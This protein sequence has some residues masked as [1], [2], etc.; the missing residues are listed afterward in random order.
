MFDYKSSRGY[1]SSS[2]PRLIPDSPALLC[3]LIMKL[4]V[5]ATLLIVV[6]CACA[7]KIVIIGAGAAGI[8]AA[9]KLFGL[10]YTDV[11]ILEAQPGLGGRIRTVSEGSKVIEFGAEWLM[12]EEGN[13]LFD[14]AQEKDIKL[15]PQIDDSD[16][17]VTIAGDRILEDDVDSL[18]NSY[19]EILAKVRTSESLVS[20]VFEAE[21]PKLAGNH[22]VHR[23]LFKYYFESITPS[24]NWSNEV[25][26]GFGSYVSIEGNTAL[27]VAA[28]ME[29]LL[30]A[31]M[32]GFG[33]LFLRKFQES[34][35]VLFG[36]ILNFN[37][38]T[39]R[40]MLCKI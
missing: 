12:G 24:A 19:V 18:W 16:V 22:D 9:S 7:E 34:L 28:G 31:I 3:S 15:V 2:V 37:S 35:G 8:A 17:Y 1:L 5:L 30:R 6:G 26:V 36:L 32:V 38:A 21:L 4:A 25:G 13:F 20:E 10:G 11:Q 14:L 33:G 39:L 40:S 23:A 29:H 27:G